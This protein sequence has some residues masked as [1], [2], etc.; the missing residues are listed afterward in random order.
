MSRLLEEREGIKM[1]PQGIGKRRKKLLA[2]LQ[3][4]FPNN[5]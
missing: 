3:E 5:P 4:Y 1:T 2:T